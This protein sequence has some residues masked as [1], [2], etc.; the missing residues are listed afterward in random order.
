MDELLTEFK[1]E[2]KGL[3]EDLVNI[4]EEI[5]GKF[6]QYKRLE[7][8]GQIVDRIMGGASSLAHAINV[9]QLVQIS[10]YSELCKLVGYK[11]SQNTSDEQLYTI[12]VAFLLDAVEMLQI[13]IDNLGDDHAKPIKELV[14]NTFLDRLRWIDKRFAAGL[15]VSVAVKS[16]KEQSQ[17]DID[18]LLKT[19]GLG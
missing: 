4:L 17:D 8:F 3:A 11:G 1:A 9:P 2:S 14:S 12:V 10:K 15:R 5:E 6:S 18:Q 16:D 19:L 7:E 13:M